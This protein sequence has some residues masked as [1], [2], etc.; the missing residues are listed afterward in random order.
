M[1]FNETFFANLGKS[2][3][4]TNLCLD[5]ANKIAELARSTAP[6]DEGDYRDSIQVVTKEATKRN[7]VLVVAGNWKSMI[8]E[9]KTGNLVRALN[10]VKK[11]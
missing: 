6:I 1:E 2:A 8:I 5:R 7:V 10:K 11:T 4:V 3:E 9:A